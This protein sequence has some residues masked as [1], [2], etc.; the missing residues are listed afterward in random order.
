MTTTIVKHNPLT[1]ISDERWI[2]FVDLITDNVLALNSRKLSKVEIFYTEGGHYPAA[3]FR[4]TTILDDAADDDL[5]TEVSGFVFGFNN[6]WDDDVY[7]HPLSPQ[8]YWEDWLKENEITAT[9]NYHE[10]GLRKLNEFLENELQVWKLPRN[11][12][13]FEFIPN[14]W[15]LLKRC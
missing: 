13:T 5:K 2:K 11:T 1:Q 10:V 9:F 6:D 14:E 4:L 12:D 3:Y 7:I 15:R 8:G